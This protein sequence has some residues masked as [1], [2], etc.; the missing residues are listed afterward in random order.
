MILAILLRNQ[1]I[2]VGESDIDIDTIAKAE[3]K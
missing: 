3:E 1:E 2:V